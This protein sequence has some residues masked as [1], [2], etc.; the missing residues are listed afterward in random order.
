MWMP[1]IC[2]T[3]RSRP[4]RSDPIHASMRAADSATNRREAADF[5]TPAP[6]GVGTSPSGRRT[7]RWNLLVE[8][9][10]SMRLNAHLPS[11]SSSIAL[12]QLGKESSFPLTSRTRGRSIST[13]PP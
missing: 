1:S 9:L 4:E 11:Q 8:T 12:S 5:D 3:M 13:F 10:I 6:E 2:T 7:A